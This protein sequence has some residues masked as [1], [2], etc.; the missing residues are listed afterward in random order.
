MLKLVAMA[1]VMVT[2]AACTGMNHTQQRVLSGA[3]I[4][5]GGGMAVGAVSEDVDIAEGAAWGAAAGAVGGLLVDGV[6]N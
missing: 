5:A 6:S 2:L 3:A 4:G 1:F